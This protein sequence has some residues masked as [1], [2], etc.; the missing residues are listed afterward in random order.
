MSAK[1]F[2]EINRCF[3]DLI[4]KVYETKKENLK[5]TGKF[6]VNESFIVKEGILKNKESNDSCC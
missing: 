2:D 6:S 4:K 5:M 3:E 1:R